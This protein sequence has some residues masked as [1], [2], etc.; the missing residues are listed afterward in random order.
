MAVNKITLDVGRL[1]TI[2]E[3][4]KNA[5]ILI[6]VISF[7]LGVLNFS[8]FIKVFLITFLILSFIFPIISFYN[9]FC[10]RFGV[11]F[12]KKNQTKL[13]QALKNQGFQIDFS[14]NGLVLD[15]KQKKMIFLSNTN[16]DVLICDYT[17]IRSWHTQ[18]LTET[19]Q[20]RNHENAYAGSK[21]T[22]QMISIVVYTA[23]PTYPEAR[24]NVPDE[25]SASLWTGRL[26]ALING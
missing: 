2:K 16:P 12:I 23:S 25:R 3:L 21:T 4:Y 26:N 13:E 10:I 15:D 17:D 11:G 14:A 8:S 19:K 6:T 18:T 24:F 20:Y 22:T 5:A 1:S 9:L 7:I